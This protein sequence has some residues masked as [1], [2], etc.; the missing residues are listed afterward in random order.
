MNL[1]IKLLIL[2]LGMVVLVQSHAQEQAKEKD[3]AQKEV[4]ALQGTWNTATLTYNGKDVLAAGKGGFHFVFKGDEAAIEGN[5]A[6]K[7]EYAKIKVKLD[8]AVTPKCIDI[9]V[10][11]GV[12]LNAVIEGI[13][14]LK[15][16]EL[17][18]CAKVF[19]KDRPAEFSSPDGSSIV[20][21]VLKREGP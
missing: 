14:E 21:L 15:E 1:K 13:Y 8:P 3:A 12:Q 19:G 17:K 20:L 18:I 7:K 2:A 4:D 9:T 10:T 5:E 16:N 11:G 6:V